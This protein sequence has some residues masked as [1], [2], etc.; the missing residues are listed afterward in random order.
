MGQSFVLIT[1]RH[2]ARFDFLSVVNMRKQVQHRFEG[3]NHRL[4]REDLEQ[5]ARDTGT[6]RRHE[7]ENGLNE[8]PLKSVP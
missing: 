8:C 4:S 5:R 3:G 1:Q 6:T 7:N 2:L